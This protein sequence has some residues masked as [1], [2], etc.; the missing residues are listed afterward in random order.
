MKYIIIAFLL[1]LCSCNSSK[2]YT[3]KEKSTIKK[4]DSLISDFKKDRILDYRE[5]QDFNDKTQ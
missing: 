4:S 5:E 3:E 2:V 1:I